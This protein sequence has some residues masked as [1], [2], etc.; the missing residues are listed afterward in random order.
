MPHWMLAPINDR[1]EIWQSYSVQRIVVEAPDDPEAR[2]RLAEAA[3]EA[4]PPN[5]WPDP[6]LTSCERSSLTRRRLDRLGGLGCLCRSGRARAATRPGIATRARRIKLPCFE[7]VRPVD[8]QQ[9][10]E[11]TNPMLQR[12]LLR[13]RRYPLPAQRSQIATASRK[14]SQ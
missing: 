7:V 11:L 6:A 9:R 12:L 4:P 5:P 1:A 8:L 3:L 10:L 13:S 2:R 14:L